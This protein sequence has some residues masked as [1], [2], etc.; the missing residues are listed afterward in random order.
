MVDAPAY[1]ESDERAAEDALQLLDRAQGASGGI[2]SGVADKQNRMTR[3]AHHV[4]RKVMGGGVFAEHA[5]GDYEELAI[6]FQFPE[7]ALLQHLQIKRLMEIEI[8]PSIGRTR[9]DQGA[10]SQ[11]E[12]KPSS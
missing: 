9:R 6:H 1:P 11:V 7:I 5:G 2:G 10:V 4:L 12:L 8:R 3:I